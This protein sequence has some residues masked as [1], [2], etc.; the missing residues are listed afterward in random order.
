[1]QILSENKFS[2]SALPF[3]REELTAK[4]HACELKKYGGTVLCADYKMSGLGSGSCGPYAAD[5]F[6]LKEKEFIFCFTVRWS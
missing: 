1:M 2:F 6:L 5:E 3:S 4:K